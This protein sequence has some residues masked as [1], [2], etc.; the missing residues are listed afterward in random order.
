MNTTVRVLKDA[1]SPLKSENTLMVCAATTSG[2]PLHTH[3]DPDTGEKSGAGFQ[4][5][6]EKVEPSAANPT[7]TKRQTVW[8]LTDEK[9]E[10]R[11]I[12]ACETID[13]AEFIR[14]YKD[15]EW[16]AANPDHPI[17]Y[18]A[19][20]HETY[21][22][23]REKLRDHKPTLMIRRGNRVAFIPPHATK[24]ESDKILGLL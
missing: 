14:R 20:M 18:M 23:L 19:W 3:I 7:G 8:L 15:K 2:I 22:R 9:I 13:T 17:A 12:P 11:P 6:I 24:E 16:R 10:F 21:S 1:T 4:E 5:T